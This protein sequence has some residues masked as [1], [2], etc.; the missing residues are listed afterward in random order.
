MPIK[1][2]ET[3]QRFTDKKLLVKGLKRLALSIPVL[4]LTT[5]AL[6]FAFLNKE[7]LPLYIVLPL[8]IIGVV[9][10]VFLMFGGIKIILKSVFG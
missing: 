3:N 10:T 2:D 9:A 5:Y 6:T 7:V 4:V 8:G 1:M